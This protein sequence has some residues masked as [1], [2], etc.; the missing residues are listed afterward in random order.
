MW[1]DLRETFQ[2]VGVDLG[3]TVD[4][5]RL[6]RTAVELT[7][8]QTKT[9]DGLVGPIGRGWL[10]QLPKLAETSCGDDVLGRGRTDGRTDRGRAVPCGCAVR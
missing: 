5:T 10:R 3:E 1:V 9:L 4:F 6:F 2:K 7:P 8:E